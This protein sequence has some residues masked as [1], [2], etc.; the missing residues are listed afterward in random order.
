VDLRLKQLREML[1]RPA[2]GEIPANPAFSASRQNS[3][4]TFRGLI[5][6]PSI[7]P[8]SSKSS[9]EPSPSFS[10]SY[11]KATRAEVAPPLWTPAA[12]GGGCC[13]CFRLL[14]AP[15]GFGL[16]QPPQDLDLAESR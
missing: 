7:V 11:T 5:R 1:N 2:C 9:D 10:R 12:S 3:L 6:L 14:E 13:S 15:L 8:H 4:V 16:Q